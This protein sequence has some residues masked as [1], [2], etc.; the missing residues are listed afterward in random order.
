MVARG[1]LTSSSRK[2]VD[3]HAIPRLLFQ[4]SELPAETVP[5]LMTA[6]L[7]FFERRLFSDVQCKQF[8]DTSFAKDPRVAARFDALPGAHRAD[9]WRYAVLLRQ[10]GAYLDVKTVGA[11]GLAEVFPAHHEKPTLYTVL[12]EQHRVR[13]V[14]NADAKRWFHEHHIVRWVHNGVIAAT[15]GHPIFRELME[16]A[17]RGQPASKVTSAFC[18]HFLRVLE[19]RFNRTLNTSGVYETQQERLVLFEER[20][21]ISLQSRECKICNNRFDRYGK[22]CV[23]YRNSSSTEPLF[24]TRDPGYPVEWMVRARTVLERPMMTCANRAMH[25]A[26]YTLASDVVQKPGPSPATEPGWCGRVPNKILTD[27]AST[28]ADHKSGFWL[29]GRVKS[30]SNVSL[31]MCIAACKCCAACAAVSFCA[32]KQACQWYRNCGNHTMTNNTAYRTWVTWRKSSTSM[33]LS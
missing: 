10:G 8:L 17:L 11:S 22:C 9:L 25:S 4:T 19:R 13:W 7:G 16:H 31:D 26:A 27:C 33:S 28:A 32:Q 2:V 23:I 20:C 14:H 15:P 1:L 3:S 5:D 18:V 30:D 24:L 29:L 21:N 6:Q 12:T